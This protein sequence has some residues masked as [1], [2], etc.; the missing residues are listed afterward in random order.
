MRAFW[1]WGILGLLLLGACRK[2]QEPVRGEETARKLLGTDTLREGA[3]WGIQIGADAKTV[4]S[5]LQ[6]L[7]SAKKIGYLSVVQDSLPRLESINKQ[8]PLYAALYLDQ[9]GGSA[10]GIQINY[11]AGRVQSIVRNDGQSLTQWPVS[12]TTAIAVQK[13]DS[14]PELYRKLLTLKKDPQ[15]APAFGWLALYYKDLQL[16]YDPAMALASQWHCSAV[17][18]YSSDAELS[19]H[20]A[21]G[22][23][24]YLVVGRFKRQ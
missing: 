1:C 11:Q 24:A 9:R 20:F 4:Y 7:R 2:D 8:L 22:R 18:S 5:M 14:L 21:D 12:A 10:Q 6:A 3:F 19:W 15:Y 13:G 17:L 23:L 16:D